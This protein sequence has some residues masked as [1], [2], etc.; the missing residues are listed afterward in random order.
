MWRPDAGPCV[1]EPREFG[2]LADDVEYMKLLKGMTKRVLKRREV[3]AKDS[4]M[5]MIK[6]K[7]EKIS[8]SVVACNL[9]MFSRNSGAGDEKASIVHVF[10]E[11]KDERRVLNAFSSSGIDLEAAEAVP[12][13][14]VSNVAHEQRIMY[15]PEPL[16]L[17][18]AY[19]YE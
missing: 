1:V 18:D 9:S 15:T 7:Q 17:Q 4:D 13:D 6:S 14:P 19:E 12:V 2:E 8:F 3:I 10:Y 11:S 5:K 16:Y